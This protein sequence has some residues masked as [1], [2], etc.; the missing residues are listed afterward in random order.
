M[1]YNNLW[2]SAS[3]NHKPYVNLPLTHLFLNA[4]W[5]CNLHQEMQTLYNTQCDWERKMER[6][7]ILKLDDWL[8]KV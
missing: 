2:T 6:R 3:H 1:I 8:L 4:M 7:K 5:L